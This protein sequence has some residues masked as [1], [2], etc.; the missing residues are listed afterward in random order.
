MES[1]AILTLM[2]KLF[3][4]GTRSPLMLIPSNLFAFREETAKRLPKDLCTFKAELMFIA[5]ATIARK[6]KKFIILMTSLALTVCW[7]ELRNSNLTMQL[8]DHT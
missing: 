7:S 8:T 1:A 2:S 4:M 3:D 6:K 5:D